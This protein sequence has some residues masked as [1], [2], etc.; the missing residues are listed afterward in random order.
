MFSK[1]QKEVEIGFERETCYKIFVENYF[2]IY[3]HPNFKKENEK[4]QNSI[5]N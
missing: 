4:L 5:M 1:L 2:T 3:K